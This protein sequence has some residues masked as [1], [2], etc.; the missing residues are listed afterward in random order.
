MEENQM[1]G[2]TVPERFSA[3]IY[4]ESKEAELLSRDGKETLA[5][6][7]IPDAGVQHMAM[8][9][10]GNEKV[11]V[12]FHSNLSTID[13]RENLLI[14][15]IALDR[16]DQGIIALSAW[17][18]G[19]GTYAV[20]YESVLRGDT[21]IS[22]LS[23]TDALVSRTMFRKLTS[24]SRPLVIHHFQRGAKAGDVIRILRTLDEVFVDVLHDRANLDQVPAKG[25][26]ISDSIRVIT[27]EPKPMHLEEWILGHVRIGG[28]NICGSK[29]VTVREN[30][31]AC[32]LVTIPGERSIFVG[33]GNG[34]MILPTSEGVCKGLAGM[35]DVITDYLTY[36][37][38][39]DFTP[40]TIKLV[41]ACEYAYD[42]VYLTEK[43]INTVSQE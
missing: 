18:K 35:I 16:S 12:S 9:H 36:R 4:W 39:D 37:A 11:L 26:A 43:L 19:N 23:S 21:P 24:G 10:V 1:E 5:R 28:R 30:L 32:A 41:N 3:I 20:H 22:V 2:T 27:T 42:A 15:H 40:P 7:S 34:V 33:Y 8:R 31:Q 38:N 13:D 6:V 17:V 25:V 29:V 14:E